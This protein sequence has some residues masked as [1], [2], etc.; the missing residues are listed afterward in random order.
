MTRFAAIPLH[1]PNFSYN[2]V[3]CE[4]LVLRRDSGSAAL[5]LSSARAL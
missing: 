4:A 3:A 2:V 1:L 5:R